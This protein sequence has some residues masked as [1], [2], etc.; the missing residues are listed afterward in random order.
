LSQGNGAAFLPSKINDFEGKANTYAAILIS[1][2]VPQLYPK[3]STFTL[4]GRLLAPP[5]VS[6]A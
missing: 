4:L 6:I 2:V 1:F 3:V 5:I